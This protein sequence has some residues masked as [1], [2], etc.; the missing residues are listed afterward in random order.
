MVGRGHFPIY[1]GNLG[2]L[3][4]QYQLKLC[5]GSTGNNTLT[6]FFGTHCQ[7]ILLA[8]LLSPTVTPWF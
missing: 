2:N 3:S 7:F 1:K 8:A 5:S 4:R 6:Y